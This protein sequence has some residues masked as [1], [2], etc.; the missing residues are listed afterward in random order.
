M[1]T[2]R[3]MRCARQFRKTRR[4]PKRFSNRRRSEG[5]LPPLGLQRRTKKANTAFILKLSSNR[6]RCFIRLWC[7][8]GGGSLPEGRRQKSG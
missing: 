2:R 1:E 6:L 3:N 5:W 7:H 4:R 8:P